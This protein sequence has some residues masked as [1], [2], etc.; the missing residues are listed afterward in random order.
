MG[1]CGTYSSVP[2][3]T[4]EELRATFSGGFLPSSLPT[5]ENGLA[6]DTQISTQINSLKSQGLLPTPP[7]ITQIQSTPFNSPDSSE[8]LSVYV[9]KVNT[10]DETLK[11]EY[12]YYEKRYFASLN[13]FLSALANNSL[14]GNQDTV[15]TGHLNLT[16]QLNMKLTYLTQLANAIAKERY[17]VTSEFQTGIN[18]SNT[19]IQ[20]QQ[21]KLLEQRTIL[22]K[23][24]SSVD[25]YKRMV[26]YTAEKN[27]A[28]QNL[29]AMYGILNVTALAM[30]FYVARS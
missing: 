21:Q 14:G 4:N 27:R 2:S 23:E 22:S 26:E 19:T 10:A 18:S 1:V 20:S 12:C 15:I 25:L 29:L 3:F 7:S 24:S 28:N 9:T 17:S 30:I 16:K 6:T 8:P 5:M 13:S 11:N